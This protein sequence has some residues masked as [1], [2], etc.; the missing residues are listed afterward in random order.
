MNDP[1]SGNSLRGAPVLSIF[2][3]SA[4]QDIYAIVLG[5]FLKIASPPG[6]KDQGGGPR[7]NLCWSSLLLGSF[8]ALEVHEPNGL[9]EVGVLA[10]SKQPVVLVKENQL[11]S[12]VVVQPSPKLTVNE[13]EATPVAF[14]GTSDR[15]Q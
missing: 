14:R 2:A 15:Y 10:G 4:N 12:F 13:A 9:L 7:T 8:T 5:K 11:L 1:I 6:G 3:I